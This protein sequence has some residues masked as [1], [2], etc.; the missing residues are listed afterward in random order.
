MRDIM[1]DLETLGVEPGCIVLSVGAVQFGPEGL[2]ARFYATLNVADQ[3]ELGLV[4][5]PATLAWWESQSPEARSVLTEP[6]AELSAELHNFSMFC[7]AAG[8]VNQVR[9]WG[10]GADFDNPI[11]S[12]VYKKAGRAQPWG[13]YRNRCYRTLKG[14]APDDKIRRSGTHH[15]ALADAV[16]QAEHAVYLLGKLNLWSGLK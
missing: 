12:T 8:G 14:F 15:N 9:V 3:E 7:A 6:A 11:L 1:L 4:R 16:S 13:T 2:G 10:N 5:N